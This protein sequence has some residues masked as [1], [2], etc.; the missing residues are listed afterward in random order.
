MDAGDECRSESDQANERDVQRVQPPDQAD[1][2]PPV[3]RRAIVI[4]V[5]LSSCAFAVGGAFMKPSLG[6]T[7][8]L[9]SGIVIAC[10][11]VGVI[12]MTLA[13]QRGSLGRTYLIGLGIEALA[14]VAIGV[15]VLGE[16]MTTVQ[17]AGL[18]L[19]IGGLLLVRR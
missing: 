8:W 16:R 2:P 10:F 1:D 15:V 4:P 9:P 18:A 7:R 19:V 3:R 12:G 11:L 5:L 6:F 17:T 14:A 13:V